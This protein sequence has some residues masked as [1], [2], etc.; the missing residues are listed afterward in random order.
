MSNLR[1]FDPMFN[2]PFVPFTGVLNL[3]LS[4]KEAATSKRLAIQ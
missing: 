1:V 4:K 2:E 3:E